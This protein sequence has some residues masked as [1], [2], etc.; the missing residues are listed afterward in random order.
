MAGRERNPER[1]RERILDA[2][3]EEFAAHGYAGARTQVIAQRAGLNK[4]LISHHFGGKRALYQAVM[5]ERRLR[6]GGEL[7][8][9]AAQLPDALAA[10]LAAAA[11]DPEWLR[12][13]LW[14][15]LE[16]DDEDQGAAGAEQRRARY[17]DRVA[18][19]A[20]EQ[21]A[22]RAPAGL[23]PAMLLLSLFGAVLYPLLLPDVCELVSGSR[24]DD[25]AFLSRYG[26]HLVALAGSL[27]A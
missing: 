14:E 19:I 1:S 10:F 9:T 3:L 15:S 20:T 23:D 11:N 16:A 12:V 6:G 18:W 27:G 21:A 8:G 4:Q 5:A 25:P 24:P 2:A 22:G 26:D 7:M 17:A 13:L